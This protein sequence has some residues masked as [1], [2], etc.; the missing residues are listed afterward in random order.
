MIWAVLTFLGVPLWLCAI[1]VGVLV[2]HNRELRKRAGD[3]PVRVLRPG[4]KRWARAHAIWVSD[5]FAWRASPAGWSEHI[6]KVTGVSPRVASPEEHKK[7][8]RLA[9]DPVVVSLA[10]AEGTTLEVATTPEYAS[11][12]LGPVRGHD[13]LRA[14]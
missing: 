7:L 10:L 11:D 5:V 12:L 2:Y 9:D 14:V 1:G 6:L 4:K 13:R 8:H 3:I